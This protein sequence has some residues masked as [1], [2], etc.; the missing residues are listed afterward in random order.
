MYTVFIGSNAIDEYYDCSNYPREGDKAMVNYQGSYAGG[1]VA[2]SACIFAATGEVALMIDQIGMTT[3]DELILR[4]LEFH[5]VDTAAIT[6]SPTTQGYRCHIYRTKKESTIFVV[7]GQKERYRLNEQQLNYIENA[8]AIY[9]TVHELRNLI[10]LPE[11]MSLIRVKKNILMLDVEDNAYDTFENDQV[12]FD[13][14]TLLSFSESGFN[15]MK[16]ELGDRTIQRLLNNKTKKVLITRGGKG[17]ELHTLAGTIMQDARPADVADTTGAGD[18]FNAIFL[19]GKIKGMDDRQALENA[20]QFS[21]KAT[22]CI[23]P[24]GCIEEIKKAFR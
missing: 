9:S 6:R 16:A 21:S 4:D 11:L 20:I 5:G 2:N 8:N 15:K 1:M 24:R 18:T 7:E 22:E 3:S 12:I 19:Y 17:A 23:G 14:A 10:N 13:Q